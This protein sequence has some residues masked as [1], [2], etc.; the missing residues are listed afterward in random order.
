MFVQIDQ[1]LCAGCGACIEV[2][3]VGAICLVNRRA[4]IDYDLCTTCEAC[5]DACPSGAI[6]TV[7]APAYSEPLAV[8]PTDETYLQPAREQEALPET[9]APARGLV[10]WAGAALSFLGHEVA[11]RLAD[12]LARALEQKS[13]SPTTTRISSTY[14]DAS[15]SSTS[16]ANI[17]SSG[18]GQQR[19]SRYRGGGSGRG[20]GRGRR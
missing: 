20:G 3:S 7:T 14:P 1:A 16:S 9:A 8:Q 13:A 19:Q 18:R 10:P 5:V 15:P 12:V 6:F 2:C 17:P 11:P 4:E